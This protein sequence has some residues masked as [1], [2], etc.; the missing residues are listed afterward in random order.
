MTTSKLLL[1]TLLAMLVAVTGCSRD[2]GMMDEA[3]AETMEMMDVMDHDMEGG[4][5]KAG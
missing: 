2:D 1:A 3:A 4:G 5:G